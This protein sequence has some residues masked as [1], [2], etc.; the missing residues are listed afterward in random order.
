MAKAILTSL[1]TSPSDLRRARRELE[2][3]DEFL[4]QASLRQGGKGAKL[5]P[6][7]R[8]LEDLAADSDLN[9]LKK[10]DRDRLRKFLTLLIGKAPV[11]HMSFAS[12]PS[13][14]FLGQ[15]VA[16]LRENIHPQVVVSVGL[17]PSI[18]AGCVVRTA[19]RQ[20]DLSLRQSLDNQ[21]AAFIKN[22]RGET[23]S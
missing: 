6:T 9:L 21:T 1:I 8:M 12:E 23:P 7:S 5:P 19:N 13:S 4:H 3:L 17:Q 15:L 10:T 14:K 18:A 20:F 11:I 2:A 22:L 16:W